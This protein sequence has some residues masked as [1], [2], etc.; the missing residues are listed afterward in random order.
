MPIYFKKH[1]SGWR[2]LKRILQ[3]RPHIEV[4]KK[5]L[6]VATAFNGEKAVAKIRKTIKS[7]DYKPNRPLTVILKG[8]NKPLIGTKHAQLFNSITQQVID[9]I[10]VFVGVKRSAL[11]FNIA[12]IVHN[13]ATIP[14]SSKMRGLFYY[15]YLASINQIPVDEL[16]GAAKE[17]WSLH[18]GDW[19]PLKKSTTT[20]T[21]P[22][23]QFINKAFE[24]G[25]LMKQA[26][27]NWHKA[28]KKAYKELKSMS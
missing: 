10:T 12:K 13:G 3:S 5:H 17:L 16:T 22:K 14:V 23:R 4:V 18:P 11:N 2:V 21:I 7:G 1:G 27:N 15:L 19:R 8:G 20:I 26:Q 28:L 6:A 24:D 25:A 9:P